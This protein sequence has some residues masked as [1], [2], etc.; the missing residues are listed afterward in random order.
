M[1]GVLA[2]FNVGSPAHRQRLALKHQYSVFGANVEAELRKRIAA[3]LAALK[4][5]DD[6]AEYAY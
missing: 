4:L 1:R 6:C 5:A 2:S 3:N